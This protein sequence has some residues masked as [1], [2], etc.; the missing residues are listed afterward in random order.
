M[1]A[2]FVFGDGAMGAPAGRRFSRERLLEAAMAPVERFRR[3]ILHSVT[4]L[5]LVLGG[6]GL[7]AA[8]VVA[9]LLQTVLDN[10][11]GLAG[12]VAPAAAAILLAPIGIGVAL[13]R[14]AE[15]ERWINAVRGR[16]TE[17]GNWTGPAAPREALLDTSA[18]VDGRIEEV[19]ES[20][21]VLAEL[22]VPRFVIDELRRVADSSEP[23]RRRRG[24]AGLEL[25]SRLQASEAVRTVILDE[26]P[27]PARPDEDID[28]RL[29]RLARER[30]AAL[31]TTDSNLA[32]VAALESVRALNLHAL[33]DALKTRALPGERL[34]V[35]IVEAGRGAGQGVGYLP[36]GTMVV[37][38]GASEMVGEEREVLVKRIHQTQSGRMVFAEPAEAVGAEGR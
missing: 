12:Q 36:D 27:G 35:P 34:T 33:A 32:R 4:T 16:G 9:T 21:F 31:I 30:G 37:V 28:S 13:S 24:R 15:V 10:L 2:T 29:V 20:G 11:P 3:G 26:G 17:I 14:R 25:L 5:E 1:A 6:L 18:I 19:V 22:A 7:A 8:L 23:Q 38:E